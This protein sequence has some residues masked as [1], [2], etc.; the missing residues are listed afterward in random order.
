MIIPVGKAIFDIQ[1]GFSPNLLVFHILN[2]TKAPHLFAMNF[3]EKKWINKIII[4]KIKNLSK[5][6]K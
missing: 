5:F 4:D 3:K 2:S 6:N 1:C